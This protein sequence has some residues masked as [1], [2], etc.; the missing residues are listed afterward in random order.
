MLSVS[1]DTLWRLE[2]AGRLT[3]VKLSGL[4]N[5]ST[6]YRHDELIALAQG[7]DA[8]ARDAVRAGS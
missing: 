5:G 8:L 6:Y 2:K 4:P 1:N 7:R 3:P